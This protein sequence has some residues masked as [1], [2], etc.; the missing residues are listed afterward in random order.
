MNLFA[1]SIDLGIIGSIIIIIV[2]LIFTLGSLCVPTFIVFYLIKTMTL[3][4]IKQAMGSKAWPSVEGTILFSEVQARRT[5]DVGTNYFPVISYKYVI[6]GRT[7]TGG[8]FGTSVQGMASR[9]SAERKIARYP[10]GKM[11]RV[12][13]EPDNLGNALL[14][15]GFDLDLTATILVLVPLFCIIFGIGAL[16][17]AF[18]NLMI[19]F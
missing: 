15:P 9:R 10:K 2:V 3:P 13:Y 4:Y 5:S 14:E 1:Q 8:R 18:Y 12:H 19:S 11:V 7:Y 17:V 16:L 6:N